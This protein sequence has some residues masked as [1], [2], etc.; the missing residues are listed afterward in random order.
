MTRYSL[1]RII[2]VEILISPCRHVDQICRAVIART[3]TLGMR[4]ANSSSDGFGVETSAMLTT[5]TGTR[6]FTALHR[7]RAGTAA[8]SRPRREADL[9]CV[10]AIRILPGIVKTFRCPTVATREYG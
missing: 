2:A 1:C 9:L 7:E 6:Y 3:S 4:L 10:L 5:A 8:S